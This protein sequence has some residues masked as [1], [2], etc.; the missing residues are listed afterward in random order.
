VNFAVCG[1]PATVAKSQIVGERKRG[2]PW[3]TGPGQNL[4]LS[5]LL[6]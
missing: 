6:Q 2:M 5:L 3:K 1:N 4:A